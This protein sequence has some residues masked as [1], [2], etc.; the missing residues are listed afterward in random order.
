LSI[1][2][3]LGGKKTILLHALPTIHQRKKRIRDL[4]QSIVWGASNTLE[5]NDVT[6]KHVAIGFEIARLEPATTVRATY[7]GTTS[8]RS[9]MR[10]IAL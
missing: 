10:G 6:S 2:S 9:F 4:L 8:R 5:I 1:F 3:N 7:L